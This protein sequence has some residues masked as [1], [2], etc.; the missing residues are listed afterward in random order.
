M[1]SAV[2]VI[3]LVTLELLNLTFKGC[4]FSP[5]PGITISPLDGAF[6]LGACIVIS[7]I[8][9]EVLALPDKFI[10]IS[11]GLASL[12]SLLDSNDTV[13][14]SFFNIFLISPITVTFSLFT[15][16]LTS[17]G[18]I[19]GSVSTIIGVPLVLLIF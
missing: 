7:S 1:P 6:S 2:L 15:S 12:I 18:F 9:V 17:S 5:T 14:F 8:T 16:I 11:I 4:P 19:I 13:E 10:G 3:D